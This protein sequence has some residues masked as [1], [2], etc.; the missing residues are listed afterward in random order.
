M[1]HSSKAFVARG[2]SR[3][4]YAQ[5]WISFGKKLTVMA[6]SQDQSLAPQM[7]S[8]STLCGQIS[9]AENVFAEE[10][11]RSGED[12]RDVLERYRV[13][14]RYATRYSDCGNT[15]RSVSQKLELAQSDAK[16][17]PELIVRCKDAKRAA[18]KG[19]KEAITQLIA[20][21]ANYA[22]FKVHRLTSAWTRYGAAMKRMCDT[23]IELFER[24]REVLLDLRRSANVFVQAVEKEVTK[25]IDAAPKPLAE[26]EQEQPQAE[27]QL[28]QQEERP[29]PLQQQ[30]LV[31]TDINFD[32]D[33][34]PLGVLS[35]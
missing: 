11:I 2:E 14:M 27:R 5:S 33:A 24:V 34:D 8:L 13:V 19:L 17:P 21:R 32:D 16:C 26:P 25:Q 23:E 6:V 18:L 10:E 28:Q 9:D 15:Y 3:R 7:A 30:L 12:F 4:K 29:P 20:Q 22:R 35:S 1:A 31:D